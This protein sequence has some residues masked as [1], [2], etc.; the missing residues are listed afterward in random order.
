MENTTCALTLTVGNGL[1]ARLKAS[2]MNMNQRLREKNEFLWFKLAQLTIR[3]VLKA[4][5]K[6]TK[7]KQFVWRFV[8][9]RGLYWA[10]HSNRCG[11]NFQIGG[12][13]SIFVYFP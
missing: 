1:L 8:A 6:Q 9:D 2:M 13:I 4:L 3:F 10:C 12:K 5:E 7:I 11:M